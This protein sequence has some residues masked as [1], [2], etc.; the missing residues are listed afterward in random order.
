MRKHYSRFG[1]DL[2]MFAEGAAGGD[3]AGSAG[4]AAAAAGEGT[5]GGQTGEAGVTG[6]DAAAVS[7]RAKRRNPLADVKYG[8]QPE[9]SAAQAAAVQEGTR[10]E[11]AQQPQAQPEEESFDSLIR[12]K[13]KQDFDNRVQ[14]IV[15][16]R[17]KNSKNAEA[18]LEKLQPMLEALA[19]KNGL[20][21]DDM[22]GLIRKV[23][24]DDSLYE[25]EAME[26]GIPVETLKQ[27]KNLERENQRMQRQQQE[28]QR[29]AQ[30]RGH[31]EKL[32]RQ[33]EEVAKIYPDFNLQNELRDPNFARLTS[34]GVGV[35]VRTAYEVVH[36]DR[37][38]P[39]LMQTA[40]LK[41]AAQI[42]ASVRANG[43]RPAENG[44][45]SAAAQAAE[46]KADPSKWTKA[47]REEVRRRVHRG[48]KIYL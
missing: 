27:I 38:A 8:K 37:I 12:G 43:A 6:Q 16:N 14:A 46:A 32:V 31:F 29:D 44:V 41:T 20:R 48:E 24:D 40:A 19:A 36:R 15:Q 39:A 28:A 42:S 35:D 34:P 4:T 22:D 17:L 10:P 25:D 3:G 1:M 26:R 21:A 30:L 47:D 33:G 5:T 7:E 11:A 23:T 18:Q 2:Q 9:E 13:Y 45:G